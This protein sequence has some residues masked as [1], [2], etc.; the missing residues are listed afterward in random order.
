M[1]CLDLSWANEYIRTLDGGITYQP[2]LMTQVA[3]HCLYIDDQNECIHHEEH[4]VP[5]AIH[6]KESVLRE[7]DMIQFLHRH[8]YWNNQKYLCHGFMQFHVDMDPQTVL[9][10][11]HDDDFS[12]S[13]EQCCHHYDN[14]PRDVGFAPSLFVFHSVNSMYVFFHQLTLVDK[15]AIKRGATRKKRRLIKGYSP[16]A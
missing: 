14:M 16:K 6:Q 7:E 11:V 4:N 5:L 1:D 8:Q 13:S 9:E 2:E 3:V 15:R 10:N 12:F